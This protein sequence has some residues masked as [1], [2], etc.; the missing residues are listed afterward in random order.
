MF[1]ILSVLHEHGILPQFHKALAL[2]GTKSCGKWR[3][4]IGEQMI[5]RYQ[6]FGSSS[7]SADLERPRRSVAASRSYPCRTV[8]YDAKMTRLLFA[9]LL[10]CT[11]K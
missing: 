7:L 6:E 3:S 2:R 4:R 9:N 1:K 8:R 11:S 5:S 10:D